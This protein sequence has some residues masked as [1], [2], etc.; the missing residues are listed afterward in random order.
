M[1]RI[2]KSGFVGEPQ[3]VGK[4]I[5]FR[6][7]LSNAEHTDDTL[8]W[9]VEQAR[10]ESNKLVQDANVQAQQLLEDAQQQTEELLSRIEEKKNQWQI[11]K[12]A[13]QKQAYEE[14]FAQ[15]YEEGRNKGYNDVSHLINGAQEVAASAKEALQA[16]LEENEMVILEL[17]IKAA[18]KIISQQLGGSPEK[19]LPVV[20]KG[21]KEAREMKEV[22]IYTAVQ[23]FTYLQSEREELLA[24]FPTDVK[25]YIYPEEELEP[26][27]CF[28]ETANG[29]IDISIDTQLT[30]LKAGLVEILRSTK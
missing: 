13:L 28:I 3:S 16:H 15:G 22:K 26:Y 30:E 25:L 29:R 20:K 10:R 9:T 6:Q 12:E 8:T 11:E 23:Q 1:S 7:I 19:Y 5:P 27:K 24:L 14:A 21:I 2:I 18:E 4:P 17:A